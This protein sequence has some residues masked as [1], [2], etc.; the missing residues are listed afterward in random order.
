[1][2][3]LTRTGRLPDRIAHLALLAKDGQ[4]Y[5]PGSS[6][7]HRNQELGFYSLVFLAQAWAAEGIRRPLH[8]V[9][10]TIDSQRA[11]ATDTV[12]WPE[13]STVLGPAMIIPQELA[14]VTVACVDLDLHDLV[15]ANRVRDGVDSLIDAVSRLRLPTSKPALSNHTDARAT[16]PP[17]RTRLDVLLDSLTDELL[18]P[19]TDTVVALRGDR[20]YVRDLRRVNVP[21]G[22]ATPLRQG[23]VVLI[24]GGLGGIGLTIAEQLFEAHGARLALLS[25]SPMPE[26]ERWAEVLERLGDTHPTAQRIA[27]VQALEAAGAEVLLLDG[28]VSDVARIRTVVET[29]RSRFGS[30]DGVVHAAGVIDDDL[31]VLRTQ[32]AMEDV[33]APKVY[34]T[35]VLEEATKDDDLDLFVVLSSTSTVTA[36]VGQVDYVAANS[37]LN[38]FAQARR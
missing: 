8:I 37:F 3:D 6:F 30:V 15:P 7:L 10:T 29:V 14:D 24:T 17:R 25:R 34:G 1:V 9:V 19:A 18:A 12:R 36:P 21:E 26:R 28:D 11:V 31:L 16:A 32:S 13:Q 20:R 4:E 5:R 27:R 22:E 33:L 38:A 2:R 23:G 35:L